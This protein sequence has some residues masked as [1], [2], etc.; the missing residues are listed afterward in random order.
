MNKAEINSIVEDV[1]SLHKAYMDLEQDMLTLAKAQ[2]V[3]NKNGV[4]FPDSAD[5]LWYRLFFKQ[6]G[7]YADIK[8]I[9]TR[10]YDSTWGHDELI[11]DLGGYEC[12]AAYIFAVERATGE[13]IYDIKSK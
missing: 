5:N 3:L 8:D 2:N 13:S 11:S 9:V 10:W 4:E 1:R 6:K 7:V 12:E